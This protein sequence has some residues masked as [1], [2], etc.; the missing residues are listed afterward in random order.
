MWYKQCWHGE[1]LSL[2]SAPIVVGGY[3]EV[4]FE[5]IDADEDSSHTG[6]SKRGRCDHDNCNNDRS[7]EVVDKRPC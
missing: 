4:A 7:N 1:R 6:D 3:V 5:M 2:L